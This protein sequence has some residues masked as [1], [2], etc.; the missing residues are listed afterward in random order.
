MATEMMNVRATFPANLLFRPINLSTP[1]PV[2][3]AHHLPI[4]TLLI[5]TLFRKKFTDL[6][7]HNT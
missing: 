6:A 3:F 5:L 1:I 7:H 4:H 2:N